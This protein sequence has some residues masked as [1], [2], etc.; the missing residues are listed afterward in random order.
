MTPT[1]PDL[2]TR[3]GLPTTAHVYGPTRA[4]IAAYR[5]WRNDPIFVPPPTLDQVRLLAEY[6]QDFIGEYTYPLDELKELRQRV[7]LIKTLTELADWLWDC[8]RLARL[9]PL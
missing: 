5:A 9:E 3:Y 6:C 4:A 8:R 2:Y 7:L 1:D